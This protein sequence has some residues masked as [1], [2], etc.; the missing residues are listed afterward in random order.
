MDGERFDVI[1]K[2]LAGTASRRNTLR[3]VAGIALGGLLGLPAA[4]GTVAGRRCRRA[5]RACT[6]NGQCCS[7]NCASGWCC[8][9]GE[10]AC[11]T[12]PGEGY[13]AGETA[14]CGTA[15]CARDNTNTARC[16]TSLPAGAHTLCT[17][18]G[19]PP[20]C[21]G[22]FCNGFGQCVSCLGPGDTV[23]CNATDRPCC[24]EATCDPDTRQCCAGLDASCFMSDE[25]CAGLACD[26]DFRRCK[27]A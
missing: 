19:S 15:K 14:C 21:A 3:A 4:E 17:A 26:Q 2:R 18:D 10:T 22:L 8:P 20:C 11:C 9:K 16:L 12:A 25:C 5:R 27:P 7:G 6:R 13:V 1:A 24:S 23:S